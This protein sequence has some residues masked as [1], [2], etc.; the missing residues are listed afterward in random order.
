[1][2]HSHGLKESYLKVV[3][4]LAATLDMFMRLVGASVLGKSVGWAD[5]TY[6]GG[7]CGR[8]SSM[9]HWFN[10]QIKPRF[11]HAI[12]HDGPMVLLYMVCHGSHQYTLFMLAAIYQHHGSYELIHRKSPFDLRITD[13]FFLGI[14]ANQRIKNHSNIVS[15]WKWTCVS[16]RREHHWFQWN[17]MLMIEN[18]SMI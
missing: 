14:L 16:T 7:T 4:F 12:T 13:M 17:H 5:E 9:I 10:Q 15:H 1:M 18:M 11:L 3:I 8:E 6:Q 2:E